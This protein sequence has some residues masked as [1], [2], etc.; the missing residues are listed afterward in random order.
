MKAAVMRDGRIVVDDVPEPVPGEGQVLVQTLACGICGSDLHFMR[1]APRMVE[2]SRQMAGPMTGSSLDLGRDIVMGHEFAAE[3]LEPGPDTVAP[4]A[5]TVVT[6]LP[7]LVTAEGFVSLAYNNDFPGGYAERM[8][9]S[10]PLLLEVPNGLSPQ[11]AALTEP[12]A[13][14]IH[15]VGKAGMS[16]GEAA[17]VLGCGPVG[18][19]VI[20]ALRLKGIEP[21]VATDFSPRR[22]ALARTL[23]AHESVDPREEPGIE[24]WRRVDGRK[25]LVLFEAVGVPGMIDSAVRDAPLGSRI[26]VVGV[27]MEDDVIQPAFA[28][29]KELNLQF[30]LGY[31]P[32]EFSGALRSIAEGEI[33]VA[34]LITGTVD[35]EGVPGAFDE[36]AHPDAHAKI[37][38]VPA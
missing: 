2:L 34:P 7:V 36:L 28:I 38:V 14:G 30:A 16:Q 23:G 20:A 37:L 13:V 26:V 27:C 17:L 1:H 8:L 31:D 32:V 3:V 5:G 6:S 33:D 35:I 11:Q 22:R 15:A 19:A 10:A 9:L 4:P 12:M 18:L 29:A 21:I 24:A 25:T